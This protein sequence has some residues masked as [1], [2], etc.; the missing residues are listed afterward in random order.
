M[1]PIPSRGPRRSLALTDLPSSGFRCRLLQATALYLYLPTPMEALIEIQ[2]LFR[3]YGDY[4]A[5]QDLSFAV[6]RGEVLGFLGP[7]GAGKSTTMRLITGNLAPSS[8][9]VHICGVDLL[10]QPVTAK[11][12][13]GYLPEHPPLYPDLRVDEFL[14]YCARLHGVPASKVASA[15]DRARQRCGLDESGKRLIANLSKGYRQRVGIAQ[16]I[17]HEPEVVILDE[18]TVALDPNQIRG[19]R[20]L[21]R[22]LGKEHAVLL[23]T[24]LLPEVQ[25]TC[26]R[27]LIL[28]GGRQVF[29]DNLTTISDPDH[30]PAL[31]L[32]LASPPDPSELLDLPGIREVDIL[33]ADR[34]RLSLD[35]KGDP[36]S[37]IAQ[38]VVDKGW[39]L[40]EMSGD[41]G[42]LEQI[43]VALTTGEAA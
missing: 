31:I 24:H 4:G 11:G 27:V 35:G 16:A 40:L 8:G 15:V 37:Q 2:H 5:V 43:F 29:A 38:Y 19:I 42:D 25:S 21:I 1:G 13:L 6:H 34:F 23:S 20:D 41:A 12:F 33:Q 30:P 17:V 36:R 18:P 3:Y 26:D 22:E 14:G 9:S 28:N 32:G 10:E 7:N 39:G